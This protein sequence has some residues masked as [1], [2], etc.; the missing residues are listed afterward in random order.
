MATVHGVIES[1]TSEQRTHTHTYTRTDTQRF[2]TFSYLIRSKD[3]MPKAKG[4]PNYDYH[5]E[6]L[7][8]RNNNK[9]INNHCK[10]LQWKREK[11]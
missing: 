7:N 1:D 8:L 6:C 9:S 5:L 11:F 10:S 4:C 3:L 2:T